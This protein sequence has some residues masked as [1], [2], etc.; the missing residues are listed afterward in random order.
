MSQTTAPSSDIET[1]SNP[2]GRWLAFLVAATFFMENLDGT[3]IATALPHMAASFGILPEQL[4]IGISSYMITLAICIP[5]SGWI[6]DRYGPRRVFSSA[7]L[8]FTL[9]SALC[10]LSNTLWQFV[11][12]RILQGIGGAMMVPVGRLVVLRNTS[13]RNLVNAIA[14]ITWPGLVAPILGP[15]IG[16]LIAENFSWHWIFYLNLPLGLLALLGALYLVKG[17]PGGPRPFDLVGFI[18]TALACSGLMIGMELIS[19]PQASLTLILGSLSIGLLALAYGVYHLLRSPHPLVELSALKIQSFAVTLVGG[20]FFRVAISSAPFLLPLM[21]QV[22]F[23]YDAVT[24]GMLTLWLFAGNLAMKP[25]TTWVMRTFGFRNVLLGNGLLVALGFVLC[26]LITPDTPFWII[27]AILFFSGLCRSM[28]FT[29]LNTIGFAEV[30]QAQMSGATTLF[31]IFQQLNGGM[32]IAFGAIALSLASF[33]SKHG[34]GSPGVFE[35]RFAFLLVSVVALLAL[36]DVVR[37]PKDV[38]AEVSGHRAKQA[39]S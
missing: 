15:P 34:A 13:K 24:S 31:S 7:I 6:A 11:A 3:V 14:I 18:S 2:A 35:F 37:L 19:Q 9:A 28:Q 38:G 30:S 26:A 16:G 33:F 29:V 36:I 17:D 8:V 12:A 21:F 23:G 1:A 39:R 5:I 20:S 27:A 32:G 4:S 22:A 25:A 10:G